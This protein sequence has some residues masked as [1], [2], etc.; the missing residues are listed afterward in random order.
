[1]YGTAGHEI[2]LGEVGDDVRSDA[3]FGD[4]V[5]DAGVGGDV[6]AEEFD[7]VAHEHD[8]VEGGTAAVGRHGGVGGDPVEG[9]ACGGDGE[10]ASVVD[11]VAVGGVPVEDDVHVFEETGA[12]HVDFAG[13]A[14]F[15]GRA[16]VAEGACDVVFGHEVFRRDGGEGGTGAEEIVSAAVAGGSADDGFASGDGLLGEA[17]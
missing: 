8:G 4:D 12:N 5:V 7:T 3:A 2:H 14:F 9:E 10:R 6:L 16:V 17:G 1:M 13:A 15:G 11:G